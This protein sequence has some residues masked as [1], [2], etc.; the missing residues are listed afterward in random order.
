MQE[1]FEDSIRLA[2]ALAFGSRVQE[3]FAASSGAFFKHL[4][5]ELPDLAGISSSTDA[6]LRL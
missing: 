2:G 5:L 3:L 4:L 1:P 6:S